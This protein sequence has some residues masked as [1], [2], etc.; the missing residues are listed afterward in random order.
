[1][2]NWLLNVWNK[3]MTTYASNQIA[4]LR[5]DFREVYLKCECYQKWY[6]ILL[7]LWIVENKLDVTIIHETDTELILEIITKENK[8]ILQLPLTEYKEVLLNIMKVPKDERTSEQLK[9]IL[10]TYEDNAKEF[11]KYMLSQVLVNYGNNGL[12]A[13]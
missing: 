12:N 6:N 2:K 7:M 3:I 9:D 13:Q 11:H 5:R 10:V 1:M 4:K 8:T